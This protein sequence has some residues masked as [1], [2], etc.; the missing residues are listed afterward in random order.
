M[1]SSTGRDKRLRRIAALDILPVK[2]VVGWNDLQLDEALR[3]PE[4]FRGNTVLY[5][6]ARREAIKRGLGGEEDFAASPFQSTDTAPRPREAA[7]KVL[8]FLLRDEVREEKHRRKER[9][10]KLRELLMS[11]KK[12]Q[13]SQA[14]K[15]SGLS[16]ML[17]LAAIPGGE[18][19]ALDRQ[20]D[21][22]LRRSLERRGHLVPSKE[23][24]TPPMWKRN[25]D[26]DPE[27]GSPYY[28][29]AEEFMK[30]FPGGIAEWR[31]WR[32]RTR[33]QRE[34]RNR[35]AALMPEA[36]ADDGLESFL[37]EAWE[38]EAGDGMAALAH[39]VPEGKD[40][41]AK[42]G[43]KEPKIWSDHPKWK[44][45]AEFLEAHREHFGQD[46]DD[47]ALKAA[48]DFVKYWKLTTKKPKGPRGK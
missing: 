27:E 10:E 5:A 9:K 2:P 43:D 20:L 41:V 46:A 17:R 45:I 42:L 23:T 35:I 26:Y 29:D 24:N 30:R 4:L 19:P 38:Q 1:V 25:M 32:E 28:G 21:L 31:E 37:R 44:S 8:P 12:P 34:R 6:A 22:Y 48:R 47:A 3:R 13:K 33:K 18:A 15:E 39:Y 36:P 11:T 14:K 16:R 7:E 40:D